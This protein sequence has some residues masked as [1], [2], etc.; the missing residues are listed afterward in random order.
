M[1]YFLIAIAVVLGSCAAL[2]SRSKVYDRTKAGSVRTVGVLTK[3]VDQP[4]SHYHKIVKE[5]FT[6]ALIDGLEKGGL[7]EV[8]VLDTMEN[9]K[10]DVKS[11]VTD[12]PLDA[13]LIAEWKL[14]RPASMV[15]DARVQLSLID[16]RTGQVLLTCS[17]GTKFGNSYW[18]TPHLPKTLLDAIEG[19]L[20]RMEKT[21][22]RL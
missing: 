13:L 21:M 15:T 9:E 3:R 12:V 7:F 11:Y 10:L 4:R 5:S 16:N 18:S 2:G 6:R 20:R 1:K 19:A 22:K 14:D 17:H 8:T